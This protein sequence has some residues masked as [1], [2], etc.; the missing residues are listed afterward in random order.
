MV[1]CDWC[2]KEV[3]AVEDYTDVIGT[4]RYICKACR[5]TVDNCECR[6]CGTLTDPSMM[7]DGLCTTCVQAQ[8]YEKSKLREEVDY[9]SQEAIDAT[10]GKKMTNEDLQIWLTLGNSYSPNDM[11]S[12]EMKRLWIMVKLGT[13]GITD[14]K[15]M[16]E[17]IDCMEKMLDRNFTKLIGH[18]CDVIAAKDSESRKRVRQSKVIDFEKDV[19]IVEAE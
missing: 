14:E 15:D 13:S 4:I 9:G 3:E 7:I 6:K 11:R 2:K 12:H 18:R 8:I 10:G 1:K 16:P 17:Y 19:Y 5:E